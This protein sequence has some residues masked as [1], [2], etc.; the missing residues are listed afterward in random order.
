MKNSHATKIKE[1]QEK[2]LKFN[3]R[4][5]RNWSVQIEELV[6]EVLT[7]GIMHTISDLQSCG[8]QRRRTL[9]EK[10]GNVRKNIL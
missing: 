3:L 8:V 10:S 7:T 5:W 1:D 6:I 9:R 4:E 2:R